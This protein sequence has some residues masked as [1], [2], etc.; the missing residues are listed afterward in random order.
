MAQRKA[1]TR[2]KTTSTRTSKK[3]APKTTVSKETAIKNYEKRNQAYSVVLFAIGLLL[4]LVA[5]IRGEAFWSF[6]HDVLF[7]FFGL[8]GFIIGPATIYVAVLIAINKRTVRVRTRVFQLS[9]GILLACAALHLL[10]DGEHLGVGFFKTFPELYKMGVELNGGGIFS[11]IIAYP[12]LLTS[13]LGAIILTILIAFV[14]LMLISNLTLI[15]FLKAISSPFRKL[16][17]VIKE[18]K[19]NADEETRIA[20][21]E[22]NRSLLDRLL[23]TEIKKD[24]KFNEIQ[25]T[26]NTAPR[27]NE[28]DDSDPLYDEQ[29]EKSAEFLKEIKKYTHDESKKAG[30]PNVASDFDKAIEQYETEENSSNIPDIAPKNESNLPDLE[31]IDEQYTQA[32]LDDKETNKYLHTLEKY[33]LPTIDLLDPPVKN[34][35]KTNDINAELEKNSKTLINTLN[36]FGVKTKIVGVSRGPSVTRYEIQPAAGVKISKITSLVDDIS[37]S[38]ATAG[39]RIEAPIPNKPAVG[40]EVPNRDT[41]TVHIRA[42][43]D[44]KAFQDSQSNLTAVLGMDISGE[45]V[46]ADI[47]KMPHLLIAGTTGSGKSV[48]VNSIIMSILFKS[49]PDE[50][51]L[52]MIDP[53]AVEFMIYN[54]IPHLLIPVVTDPKKASGALAWAVTEMLNRYKMFSENNVRDLKGFNE[55]AQNSEELQ[56]LPQIVIFIDELADLMMAAPSEVEDSIFRLAQMAR[57]AGMHLVIAT[58]RPSVNVVTGVIKANIPSRIALKVASQVDSRTILDSAG[59]EKLLG[60]GDMLF[61]PVGIPKPVRVQGCWVS[62]KEVDRVVDFIKKSFLLEYDENVMAEVEKQAELVGSKEKGKSSSSEDFGDIQ[63]EKLEDAID[64]VFEAGQA[65]TSYLQRK[66]K[67]GYGRAARLIDAMEQMGIVGGYEGSKPRQLTMTRQEWNE[68]KINMSN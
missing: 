22:H 4:T 42:M 30:V 66:L 57:A 3:P 26:V 55:L 21:E 48:C 13:R 37:L 39:V 43:L 2:A 47:A 67:L 10:F 62:D 14:F 29:A 34:H 44:S 24:E 35:A 8:A 20:R 53:K 1:P 6:L 12:L 45:I 61:F 7:G 64:A 60:K 49:T 16:F 56:K 51:R 9:F 27:E 17:K 5:V 15:Q 31:L 41:E 18:Q 58:Q 52:L 54:G 28:I 65:S 38:L 23:D 40:I 63:D 32:R 59:A 25:K 33:T 11:V 46:T 50:V 68:R 19:A 36:S